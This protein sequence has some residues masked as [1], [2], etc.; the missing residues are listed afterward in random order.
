MKNR[1]IPWRMGLALFLFGGSPE[2][3]PPEILSAQQFGQPAIIPPPAASTQNNGTTTGVSPFAASQSGDRG[4]VASP[5]RPPVANQGTT[6]WQSRGSNSGV[7]NRNSSTANAAPLAHIAKV[8]PG[9]EVLPRTA[10]QVWRNYDISPFTSKFPKE[11]RPQQE[12]IDW[13]LRETGTDLWFN[14]PLGILNATS[15]T[16][17]VYHSPEVQA[18]VYDIVDRFV[19]PKAAN[20]V[21]TFHVVTVGSPNWR[22]RA[23]SILQPIQVQSDGIQGWLVSRENAAVLLGELKRRSDFREIQG[24]SIYVPSGHTEFLHRT[25]PV[26]YIESLIPNPANPIAAMLM[27]GSLNEGYA[28]EVSSLKSREGDLIEAVVKC[29]VNQLEK[30]QTVNIDLRNPL[31]QAQRSMIQVPQVVTWRLHERFKWPAD[32]VLLLSCGVVA[33]PGSTSNGL[34]PIPGLQSSGRAD[35]L[36]FFEVKR[37]SETTGLPTT[38]G[39]AAATAVRPSVNSQG[40]Y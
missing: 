18:T 24:P 10:G 34:I 33:T 25:R 30:F 17:R 19:D 1:S 27:N 35:A 16:L 32:K 28:L 23:F 5:V 4:S 38:G 2:L 37:A 14:E 6:D 21:L 31:G 15:D 7:K 13:I 3:L 36:L 9:G 26:N 12:I 22:S 11:S 8:T 20:D 40:R 29:H 39:N